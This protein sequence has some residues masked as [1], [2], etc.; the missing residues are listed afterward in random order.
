MDEKYHPKIIGRRGALITQIR[1]KHDVNVQFPEKGSDNQGQIS[2]IGYQ[3]NTEACRDEILG[4]IKE[5]VSQPFVLSIYNIVL[6]NGAVMRQM[7]YYL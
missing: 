4:I 6:N 1:K 5:Y 3:A 2:I 7:R